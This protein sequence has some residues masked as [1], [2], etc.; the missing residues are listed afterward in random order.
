M[1]LTYSRAVLFRPPFSVMCFLYRVTEVEDEEYCLIPMGGVLP[2]VPQRILGNGGSAGM[3]HPSTGRPLQLRP[4]CSQTP[5]P[6]FAPIDSL[7]TRR[8]L[9][10][11]NSASSGAGFV[12]SAGLWASCRSG[13]CAVIQCELELYVKAAAW[14]CCCRWLSGLE[15]RWPACRLLSVAACSM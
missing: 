8:I 4:P 6:L 9:C 14:T 7:I 11:L 12:L 10:R 1:Q 3:V 13:F 15:C 5:P 2:E